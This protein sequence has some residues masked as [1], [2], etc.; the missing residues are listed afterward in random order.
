MKER[1][2]EIVNLSKSKFSRKISLS[3]FNYKGLNFPIRILKNIEKL[4]CNT[5]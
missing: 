2:R 3:K 5:I 1:E 4:E